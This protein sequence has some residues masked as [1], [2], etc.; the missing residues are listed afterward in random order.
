M[1]L[2]IDVTPQAEAWLSAEAQQRGLLP[3]DVARRVIE[4]RA[5]AAAPTAPTVA[6]ENAAAIAYLD[7]KLKE[8][9]TDDPEEIRRAE[10][11]FEELKRNLNANRAATGERLVFP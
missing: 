4:E 5:S 8:D 10:Q 11:E 7:R 2:H 6:A 3:T 9:A 1:T